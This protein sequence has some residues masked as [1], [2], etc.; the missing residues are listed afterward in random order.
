MGDILSSRID[1][2]EQMNINI[3]SIVKYVLDFF[4]ERMSLLA[5]CSV[6]QGCLKKYCNL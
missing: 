3:I 6:Y 2:I 5:M 1:R 4:L